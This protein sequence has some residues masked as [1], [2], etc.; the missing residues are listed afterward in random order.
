M[1]ITSIC[2]SPTCEEWEEIRIKNY[3]RWANTFAYASDED[4]ITAEVIDKVLDTFS[5]FDPRDKSAARYVARV[6]KVSSQDKVKIL[7][8]RINR[9]R[10]LKRESSTFYGGLI[11]IL[12][13]GEVRI[14][15]GQ[16]NPKL[17][18]TLKT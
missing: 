14:M 13:N 18:P 10:T 9:A 16:S 8:E 1:S 7:V 15:D 11:A 6:W 2:L 17:I 12:P 5:Y 4:R 3:E